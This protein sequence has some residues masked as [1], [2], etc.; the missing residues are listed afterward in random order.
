MIIV[1]AV[2]W[3][4]DIIPDVPYAIA[5]EFA[6]KLFNEYSIYY[7][8]CSDDPCML[9]DVIGS[10]TPL[11]KGLVDTNRLN[12]LREYQRQTLM[13]TDPDTRIVY[14]DGALDLFHAGHVEVNA[15]FL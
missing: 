5:E 15:N 3:V 2:K 4:D 1:C 14:I 11:P 8:V 6:N 12:K 13:G 10:Y 9:P 7:I